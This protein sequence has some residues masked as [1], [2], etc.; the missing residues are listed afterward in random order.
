MR[1]ASGRDFEVIIVGA[2]VIG[3]A[4]ASLLVAR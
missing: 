2:G 4:M 1:T 3:A